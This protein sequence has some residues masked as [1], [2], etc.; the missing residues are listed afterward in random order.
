MNGFSERLEKLARLIDDDKG[1][2]F[3]GLVHR[4]DAPDRWDLVVSSPA[5]EPGGVD[6]LR[7]VAGRLPKALKKSEIISL[8]RIVALPRENELLSR[9]SQDERVRPGV[10]SPLIDSRFDR[11]LL[12]RPLTK[13]DAASAK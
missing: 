10:V 2:D 9:L 3:L 6:A 13:A 1:L 7:Y 12:I 4:T 5:L 8:A 11:A